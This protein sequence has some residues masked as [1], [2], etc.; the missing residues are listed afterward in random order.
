MKIKA[1]QE[2][3]IEHCD[4]EV[5]YVLLFKDDRDTKSLHLRN[6]KELAALVKLGQLMLQASYPGY[7]SAEVDVEDGGMLGI[8]AEDDHG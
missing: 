1:I 4:E 6:R 2:E 8:P 7:R 3:R 5:G